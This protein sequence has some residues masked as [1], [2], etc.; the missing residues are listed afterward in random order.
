MY[1]RSWIQVI[2]IDFAVQSVSTC[3]AVAHYNYIPLSRAWW[4]QSVFR[5][6]IE[7]C[8][9]YIRQAFMWTCHQAFRQFSMLCLFITDTYLMLFIKSGMPCA[10]AG[11]AQFLSELLLSAHF[12]VVKGLLLW[13]PITTS[14]NPMPVTDMYTYI[15]IEK[16]LLHI[17]LSCFSNK[18]LCQ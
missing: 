12:L 17:V 5:W 3:I 10:C 2:H 6:R 15:C 1:V 16:M 14:S 13:C 9:M 4:V 11:S 7:K 8:W 18:E